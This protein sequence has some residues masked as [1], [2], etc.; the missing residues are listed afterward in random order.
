[1][2]N[3]NNT[4]PEGV[5]LVITKSTVDGQKV[6]RSAPYRVAT[7]EDIAT[8]L[9]SDN[10]ELVEQTVD[11]YNLGITG[12][13]RNHINAGRTEGRGIIDAQAV[14]EMT[15]EAAAN[16]Q[17]NSEGLA[18]FREVVGLVV[19]VAEASGM[20][21]AGCAK[22]RKLVSSPVGLSMASESHKAKIAQLLEATAG[23]LSDDDMARLATPFGKLVEAT[24]AEDDGDEW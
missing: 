20:S 9:A 16:R 21:A 5:E 23:A 4:L 10:A 17:S 1:M 24:Q 15:A 18:A 14:L 8:L 13:L 6:E 7:A 22:V 2:E 11:C 19:K 12:R 3:E